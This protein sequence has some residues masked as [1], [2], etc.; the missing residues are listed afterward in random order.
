MPAKGKQGWFKNAGECV[1]GVMDAREEDKG[2][3]GAFKSM[4]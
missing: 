2:E 1:G 4:Q 3:C